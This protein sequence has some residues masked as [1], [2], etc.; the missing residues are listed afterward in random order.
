ML[1]RGLHKCLLLLVSVSQ[2]FTVILSEALSI[3]NLLIN[4]LQT[5][6]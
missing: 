3:I 6:A 5:T 2:I 1:C 4:P